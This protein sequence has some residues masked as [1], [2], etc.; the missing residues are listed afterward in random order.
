MPLTKTTIGGTIIGANGKPVAGTPVTALLSEPIHNGL[1]TQAAT[2]VTAYTNAAGEW[3]HTL[4][5]NGDPGTFPVGTYHTLECAAT[6]WK[7]HV[8]VPPNVG[9]GLVQVATLAEL[10]GPP[11]AEV[12]AVVTTTPTTGAY[13]FTKTQAEALITL[14]NA[15]REAVINGNLMK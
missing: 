14:A 8:S 6:G 7:A 13:G 11:I 2:E 15:L 1:A 3:H 4:A 9:Q 10:P 12:P 5:S